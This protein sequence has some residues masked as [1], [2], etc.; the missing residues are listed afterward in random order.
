MLNFLFG[1]LSS[2][3]GALAYAG[4]LKIAARPKLARIVAIVLLG[5]LII[6]ASVW[7]GYLIGLKAG[8]EPDHIYLLGH[9]RDQGEEQKRNAYP[10]R[11]RSEVDRQFENLF[12]R[13]DVHRKHDADEA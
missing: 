2:V 8:K 5:A 11:E 4:M 7:V 3:V 10:V 9:Q 12:A 6:G 1:V 13:Q